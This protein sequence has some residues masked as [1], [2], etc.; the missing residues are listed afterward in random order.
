MSSGMPPDASQGPQDESLPEVVQV[1]R[2]AG[3]VVC[4]RCGRVW[5]P[6]TG[7][8]TWSIGTVSGQPGLFCTPCVRQVEREVDIALQTEPWDA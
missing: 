1:P 5:V 7:A 2:K 3:E 8:P 6:S 4:A